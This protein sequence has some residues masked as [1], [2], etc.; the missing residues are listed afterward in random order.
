MQIPYFDLKIH[1]WGGLG[2]QLYAWA[3]LED[4]RV[5]FPRRRII[6]VMHNSGVTRRDEELSEFFDSKE[7]SVISDY[8]FDAQR[9]NKIVVRARTRIQVLIKNLLNVLGFIATANTDLEYSKLRPWVLSL[10]GHYTKRLISSGSI[11]KILNSLENS[12][13]P[14][15]TDSGGLRLGLHFRLGDLLTLDS[16]SPLSISRLTQGL[17]SAIQ[18]GKFSSCWVFSDSPLEAGVLLRE[19]FPHVE[20]IFSQT[21]AQNAIM[22]LL[23]VDTFVGTPS[24]ISEWVALIRIHTSTTPNVFL[25]WDMKGQIETTLGKG[26]KIVFY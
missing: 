12:R 14:S 22:E 16:K 3:L 8:N 25:P 4:L 9:F 26:S 24:K 20:F 5:K 1:V 21:N 10:R 6:L 2:S 18:S 17:R 15:G 19:S 23:R 11:N 13:L 7:I